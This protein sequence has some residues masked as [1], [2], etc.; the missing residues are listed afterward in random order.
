[1][2]EEL[3]FNCTGEGDEDI[4]EGDTGP[5]LLVRRMCLMLCANEDEWLR[6]NIF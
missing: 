6:K 4:L 2:G 3:M 5:T 1:M